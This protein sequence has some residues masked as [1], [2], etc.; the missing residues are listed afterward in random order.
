MYLV[1]NTKIRL[2]YIF[3]INI[4]DTEFI[5]TLQTVQKNM[6]QGKVLNFHRKQN[7]YLTK[8]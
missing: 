4:L 5:Y 7:Y 8:C 3:N 2:F 6:D 1:N